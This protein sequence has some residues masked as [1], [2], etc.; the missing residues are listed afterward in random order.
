M[1]IEYI[2]FTM[3]YIVYCLFSITFLGSKNT[4][5]FYI[6]IFLI[7]VN[8]VGSKFKIH[9]SFLKRREKPKNKSKRGFLSCRK[10]QLNFFFGVTQK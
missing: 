10:N 1:N 8:L 3:M 5:M 9:R 6:S 2:D 7:E 4:L